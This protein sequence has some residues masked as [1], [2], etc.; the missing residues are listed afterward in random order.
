[1][2]SVEGKLYAGKMPCD[3]F[4]RDGRENGDVIDSLELAIM[5]MGALPERRLPR[6]LAR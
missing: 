3:L 2:S 4:R 6:F 1:V 5:A